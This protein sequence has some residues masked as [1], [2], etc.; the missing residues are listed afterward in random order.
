MYKKL[1]TACMAI[2]AFAAFVVPSTASATNDPTLTE[3]GSPL[4]VGAKIV[5]T[6]V[7]EIIMTDTSGT[8]LLS[9]TSAVMTGEVVQNSGGTIVTTITTY[10]FWSTGETSLHN[11]LPECTGSFANAYITVTG[12]RC[13]R[14]TP[15]MATDEFQVHKGACGGTQE[16]V[17]FVIGATVLGACGYRSTGNIKGDYTTGSHDTL[18]MRNTQAGS[19]TTKISGSFLCPSSFALKITFS[20]ETH[21]GTTVTIS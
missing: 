6:N 21:D 13:I 14:S 19:G 2:A 1:L 9:C 18:T 4:A 17:E 8:A 3:N 10:D 11:N 15:A 20:L 7:G 5:G 16:Q 12:D